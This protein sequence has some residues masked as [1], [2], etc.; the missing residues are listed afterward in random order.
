ME[1]LAGSLCEALP[2]VMLS[3]SA[4][5]L[6]LTEV[7]DG[8]LLGQSMEADLKDSTEAKGSHSTGSPCVRNTCRGLRHTHTT[9]GACPLAVL[10]QYRP[11]A[12]RDV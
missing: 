9:C 12:V 2:L 5:R 6:G 4:L 3:F 10:Y 7:V 8:L 1:G 11:D